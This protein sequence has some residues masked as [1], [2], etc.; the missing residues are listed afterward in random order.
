MEGEVIFYICCVPSTLYSMSLLIFTPV[1]SEVNT[2]LPI[3]Q[4]RKLKK[5]I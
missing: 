3:V 1:L 2:I 4:K 5:E